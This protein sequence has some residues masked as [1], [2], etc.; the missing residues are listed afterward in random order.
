MANTTPSP[1]PAPVK[2]PFGLRDKIGYMFGDFGNDFTFLL[3]SMFFML[4]YTNVV[5]INPAHVGTLL[6]AARIVDGF[7]DVGM[8]IIVDKLPV[9]SGKD[10]FRRWIKYIMIP[11]A[12]ASS[13]MYMSFVADFGS[14]TAKL[15][16]MCA[17][18]F[19][20]GSI[21]Y[22][23]INIPYGSMASVISASPDDRSQLSVFR[24]TGGALAQ[25]FIMAV[26][27]MI[28][29]SKNEAGQAILDGSKMTLGAVFCSVAAVICYLV[30]YFNV[31]ERVHEGDNPADKK[32]EEKHSIGEMLKAVLTNRALGGLI[33]AALLLLLSSLFLLGMVGYIFLSYF[34]DGKLQTAGALAGLVPPLILIV[35]AP[36][37]AKK[38]GKA[39]V[40][41]VAMLSAGAV[42]IIAWV[43][44]IKIAWLWIVFYAV[45][46]FCIAIFNYLVWAFITDVIDYQEVVSGY[47][48][49]A[50]VYS[51]YSWARKLGQALA[52]GLTGWT[53][54]WIGYD[55]DAAKAGA[56]QLPEVLDKL[57]M[58]AN[59]LPGVGFVLVGL[60]LWFLYPLK[61]KIVQV[62]VVELESR[63]AQVAAQQT[64]VSASGNATTDQANQQIPDSA[65]DN[66]SNGKNV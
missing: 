3:Q 62:N 30:C 1:A 43:L 48:D 18:Y 33:A 14:Y 63:R 39:E 34:N 65:P 45:G 21:C 53:L 47:R 15:V 42:F 66:Q 40:A 36:I 37:M 50:T 35:L 64:P 52:G 23:A 12:V 55:S 13:L 6:L 54:D 32:Q 8:G 2:R 61:K 17:T 11:V 20:W 7:T 4:F 16:W 10:K 9:K 58:L 26:M 31:Q 56:A 19:L 44:H 57:Y 49:D 22:T 5:G 28:V 29:Y 51:V 60:A 38:W 41:T 27:P 25:M 24:S 46:S 59:L